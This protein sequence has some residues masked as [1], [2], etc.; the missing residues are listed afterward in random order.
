MARDPTIQVEK[1]LA[2]MGMQERLEARDGVAAF[3]QAFGEMEPEL[4]RIKKHGEVEYKKKNTEIVE[5]AFKFAKWE[6]VD[7]SI[8]PILRKHGFWLTFDSAPRVGDGGGLVVTGTLL[9]VKGHSKTASIPLALDLSGGKNNIQAAG[10]TVSY[11]CRYTT[12]MLLNL[13]YE[14]TDDDGHSGGMVFMSDDHVAELR[15]LLTD[16]KTEQAKFL[17]YYFGDQVH[18][19]T[20]V[21]DFQFAVLKQGLLNKAT[22]A[23]RVAS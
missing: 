12:R 17:F 11:G 6:D 15:R 10:S 4:P 13:H 16:T 19:I 14:G 23:A 3:N 20:E 2:I 18:D 21:E 1:L 7:D 8:R 9:H 5:K 22:G